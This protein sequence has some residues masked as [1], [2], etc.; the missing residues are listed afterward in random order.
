MA[1]MPSERQ[2]HDAAGRW[3]VDPELMRIRMR[4]LS[5]PA[6]ALVDLGRASRLVVEAS[7]ETVL[8][9]RRDDGRPPVGVVVVQIGRRWALLWQGRRHPAGDVGEVRAAAAVPAKADR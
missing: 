9:V 5:E 2:G 7:G 6:T 8:M 1:Q 3:K 4:I